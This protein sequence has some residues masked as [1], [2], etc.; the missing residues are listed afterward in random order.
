MAIWY[1][2]WPF[3]IFYGHLVYFM[4]VWY[5]LWPFGIFYGHLVYFPHFGLLYQEKSGNP[6]LI[7]HQT[8]E[9]NSRKQPVMPGA[10]VCNL[11]RDSFFNDSF[12]PPKAEDDKRNTKSRN[13]LLRN[14]SFDRRRKIRDRMLWP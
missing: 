1:I 6:V 2:L 14:C 3:G 9:T 10:D 13:W 12:F 11:I 5:I 7:V 4:A 8:L